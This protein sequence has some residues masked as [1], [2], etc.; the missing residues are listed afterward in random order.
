MFISI[1]LYIIIF[2][3]EQSHFGIFVPFI[4]LHFPALDDG[5]TGTSSFC[6]AKSVG[7]QSICPNTNPLVLGLLMELSLLLGLLMKL[8]LLLMELSLLLTGFL[9]NPSV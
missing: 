5:N 9:V 1:F 7:F 6:T 8:S 2:Q 3:L 4:E